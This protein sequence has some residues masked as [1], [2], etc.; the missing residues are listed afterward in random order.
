MAFLEC[1]YLRGVKRRDAGSI[2][3]RLL[4]RIII[5]MKNTE[6]RSPE[7]GRDALECGGFKLSE[8]CEWVRKEA[9]DTMI[10]HL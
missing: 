6:H 5:L 10:V 8:G 4:L 1:K 2:F 7:E 3:K 9:I